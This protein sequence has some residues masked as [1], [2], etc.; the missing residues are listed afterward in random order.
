MALKAAGLVISWGGD[1]GSGLSPCGYY[2]ST[3]PEGGSVTGNFVDD[4]LWS[5]TS[6]SPPWLWVCEYSPD[7]CFIQGRFIGAPGGTPG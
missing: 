6:Q 4:D 2:S 7:A 3:L 1:N 5:Y